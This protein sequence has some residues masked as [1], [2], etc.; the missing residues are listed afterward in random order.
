VSEE[1]VIPDLVQSDDRLS[2]RCMLAKCVEQAVHL[3]LV[4][5]VDALMVKAGRDLEVGDRLHEPLLCQP[6]PEWDQARESVRETLGSEFADKIDGHQELNANGV[7]SAIEPVHGELLL[8]LDACDWM[9]F[10]APLDQAF[11]VRRELTDQQRTAMLADE[12]S[13]PQYVDFDPGALARNVA[14]RLLG[15]GGWMVGDV[16]AGNATDRDIFDATFARPDRDRIDELAF[17]MGLTQPPD[18]DADGR[19]M[20]GG[21]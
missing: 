20:D 13:G 1:A 4:D 6:G 21:T 9:L 8:T 17:D 19:D 16:Y 12:Y 2:M 15:Y 14:C 10:R 3:A 11:I 7:I 18:S 5:S